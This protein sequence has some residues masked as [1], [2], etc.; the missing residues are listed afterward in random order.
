V[1]F[2][3]PTRFIKGVSTSARNTVLGNLPI[4]NWLDP[5]IYLNDFDDYTAGNWT[6]TTTTGTNALV[7]APGGVLRLSTAA[8]SSDIQHIAKLPASFNLVAGNQF[9]FTC[10]ISVNDNISGFIAGLQAGGTA[11]APTDG[12]YFQKVTGSANVDFV[13]RRASTS[14]TLT[15]V[16][17]IVAAAQTSFGFY[18]DGKQNPTIYAFS[19]TPV[20][21][22]NP[23]T[24][25]G[26]QP[27]YFLGGV[28]VGSIGNESPTST[29][30]ANLPLAATNLSQAIGIQ[31]GAA[32]IKTLDCDYMLAATEQLRY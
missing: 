8:T 9:W 26:T 2:R 20:A 18:Y 12:I 22:Q 27:L 14:T 28:M 6:T 29:S 25:F 1:S 16:T 11:F 17:T 31:A 10:S 30:L 19:S 21:A 5:R 13:I 32:A 24:A 3:T 7:A 23:L 15:A 4:P